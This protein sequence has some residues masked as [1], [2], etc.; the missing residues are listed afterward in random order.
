ML[1]IDVR[2]KVK[3]GMRKEFY[4][5][6]ISNGIAENSKGESGN[7]AYDYAFSADDEDVLLL[8]EKWVDKASQQAHTNTTHFQ[9]LG[10]LKSEY[11]LSTELN[12]L[13]VRKAV[14]TDLD[15]IFEIEV[16]S[17]PPAEAA[18]RDTYKWRLEHYPD[19]FF[20]GESDG[21]I[22][23]VVD[24]IPSAKDTI[25]DD[26]FETE[27]LPTGKNAAVLSVMTATDYRQRGMAGMLLSF[28]LDQMKNSGMTKSCLTCKEHLI[29]YYSRL[30][31]KKSG[32]SQSIHGGAIWYDM[33]QDL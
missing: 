31:F 16:E 14:P 8:N 12:M 11:V 28:T 19:Y 13:D 27:E 18:S 22:V 5:L 25:T 21:K 29:H 4:D 33:V 30:G 20:I 17:F 26:I 1:L 9:K 6:I 7:I 3:A 10:E 15:R 23:S 24:V 32:I 2:Y